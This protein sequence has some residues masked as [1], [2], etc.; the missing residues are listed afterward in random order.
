MTYQ[1]IS[2]AFLIFCGC[3]ALASSS[4]LAEVKMHNER[5]ERREI[6]LFDQSKSNKPADYAVRNGSVL[7]NPIRLEFKV[8]GMKVTP[9]GD[10]T[11]GTGH[12]HLLVD[13]TLAD[14]TKPIPYDEQHIH[15]GGGQTE[16]MLNLMPGP[17]TLQLIMGD[18]GHVPLN[19]PLMTDVIHVTVE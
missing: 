9:A 16:A 4:A 13:T 10:M 5:T 1:K 11:P 18:G 7:K 3:A 12:A 2:W 8:Y 17:H 6:Y 15:Y 19:P 14:T